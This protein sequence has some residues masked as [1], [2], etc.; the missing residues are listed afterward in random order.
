MEMS[1][2]RLFISIPVPE[3]V[4]KKIVNHRNELNLDLKWIEAS[5]FHLTLHFLGKFPESQISELHQKLLSAAK[6][7]NKF[8]LSPSN[9]NLKKGKFHKM[10]WV[11]FE[12]S[13]GFKNLVS[14]IHRELK[15]R[16]TRPAVPHINLVRFKENIPREKFPLEI[17]EDLSWEVKSFELWES[18]LDPK[19]ATY[20][21]LSSFPLKGG[22]DE[23]K[24]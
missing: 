11:N 21:S 22:S 13:D 8:I 2:H 6:Q 9:L 5:K 12:K 10:I 15:I 18:K 24:R 23:E 14:L 16:E 20:F 17:P 3:N 4:I 19:G 1:F 7:A